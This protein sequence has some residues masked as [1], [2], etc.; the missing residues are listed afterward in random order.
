[1]EPR[2][3]LSL[4]LPSGPAFHGERGEE[5]ASQDAHVLLVSCALFRQ[6]RSTVFGR[7]TV[8]STTCIMNISFSSGPAPHGCSEVSNANSFECEMSKLS[9]SLVPWKKC[10]Q[11]TGFPGHRTVFDLGHSEVKLPVTFISGSGTWM[12]TDNNITANDASTDG[13][14]RRG[15]WPPCRRVEALREASPAVRCARGPSPAKGMTPGSRQARSQLVYLT[16]S[17][18]KSSLFLP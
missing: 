15:Y 13:G 18:M 5:R 6:N 9:T 12:M 8:R 11:N 16:F 14:A 1:M 17:Y 2:P 10:V 7:N 4:A 3:C